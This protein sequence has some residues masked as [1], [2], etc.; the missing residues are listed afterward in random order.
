MGFL[1]FI[2]IVIGILA[3]AK[4]LKIL[5]SEGEIITAVCWI[6][7]FIAFLWIFRNMPIVKFDHMIGTILAV[8][9][10]GGIPA[11]LIFLIIVI[12][13]GKRDQEKDIKNREEMLEKI[14]K[15]REDEIS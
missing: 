3:G 6:L 7:G 4:Y 12:V 5:P 13:M 9:V 2:L 1:L 14:K 8:I 15:D 11:C 10:W